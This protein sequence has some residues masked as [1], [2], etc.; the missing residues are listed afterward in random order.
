MDVE[1]IKETEEEEAELT[2]IVQDFL[3]NGGDA[4]DTAILERLGNFFKKTDGKKPFVIRPNKP[5][6]L[7]RVNLKKQEKKKAKEKQRAKEA[8]EQGSSG[9]SCSSSDEKDTAPSYLSYKRKK[10][11]EEREEKEKANPVVKSSIP[12]YPLVDDTPLYPDLQQED[13]SLGREET[14]Y[15]TSGEQ[16]IMEKLKN[17]CIS[18][19]AKE[20]DEIKQEELRE[21]E[22]MLEQMPDVASR[23]YHNA[24]RSLFI[25]TNTTNYVS[26]HD[27]RELL[28]N[29]LNK[30]VVV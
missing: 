21:I 29:Y 18:N 11:L 7:P 30:R 1:A 27:I 12:Y 19:K 2:S 24:W 23:I 5:S 26:E 13:D 6:F 20:I 3:T 4:N 10:M 8:E 9:D 25:C 22:A 14:Q 17:L 28:D 16:I 15:E